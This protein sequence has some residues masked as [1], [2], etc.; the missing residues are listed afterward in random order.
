MVKSKS[1]VEFS[2]DHLFHPVMP[3]LVF[4]L[5]Q[6]AAF[7]YNEINIL[8]SV[9]ALHILVILLLMADL[10]IEII[11]SYDIILCCYLERFVFSHP[12]SYHL[13]QFLPTFCFLD[14]LLLFALQLILLISLLL[15]AET[16]LSLLFLYIFLILICWINVGCLLV[17][18]L[19]H[20]NLCRLFNAKS[21]LYK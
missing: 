2:V 3:S 11:G 15:A 16:S 12:C 18:V 9:I 14:F 21:I 13:M 10:Y 4:L 6:F 17:W 8:I 1:F 19:W 5:C 20:I 7:A